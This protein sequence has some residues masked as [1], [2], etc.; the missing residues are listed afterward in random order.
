MHGAFTS[1]LKP[2]E[3][4]E[5]GENSKRPLQHGDTGITGVVTRR[6][7]GGKILTITTLLSC[8]NHILCM[9]F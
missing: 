4:E 3:S 7:T 8:F 6:L 2:M 1:Y 9:S 5:K